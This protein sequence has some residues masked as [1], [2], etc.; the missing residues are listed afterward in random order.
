MSLPFQNTDTH[1]Q[2]ILAFNLFWV[3]FHLNLPR[4]ERGSTLSHLSPDASGVM[5]VVFVIRE[6]PDAV[7][8]SNAALARS[9][10]FLRHF[11]PAQGTHCKTLTEKMCRK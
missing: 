10:V 9:H 7:V 4:S 3:F 2:C 11:H 5:Q 8:D 1:T 6:L